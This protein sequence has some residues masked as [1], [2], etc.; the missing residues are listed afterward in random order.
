MANTV[1]TKY[2]NIRLKR[3]CFI[4]LLVLVSLCTVAQDSL[5]FSASQ[6]VNRAKLRN[7]IILESAFYLGGMSYLQWVWYNDHERVPFHFYN[8]WKGYNQIDKFGHAFGAYIESYI[9]YYL[10]RDAGVKKNQ[11]L[12]F[13]GSLGLI[14]QTPIEVFDGLYEGWGFSWYDM[15]ANALGAGILV[16]QE[17]LFDEQIVINKFSYWGSPYAD[18]ANGYLGE[19]K[20]D[21][22][23]YDYNGHSY[24]FSMPVNKFYYSEKIPDWLNVA[25]GYSAGGMFG[26]FTNRLSY[27]GVEIPET[28]RY[29][30]YLLSLDIDW[31]KI[32]TSN[33]FLKILF[34][35]MVFIKLPFPTVE[36]NSKGELKGHW[37]YY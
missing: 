34:K 31:R 15:A 12:L 9:G 29:R 21:R 1:Q 18:M 8:D 13:G 14:L 28:E 20:L 36:V 27:R 26:E 25:F 10:L 22:L 24:W 4:F 35:G 2:R 17:L 7:A 5:K 19:T 37:L 30:Q 11:A 33:R 23:M 32:K 16:G 3:F 6:G